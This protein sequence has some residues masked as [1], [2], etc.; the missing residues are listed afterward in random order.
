MKKN[1]FVI[2]VMCLVLTSCGKVTGN[3]GGRFPLPQTA[4]IFLI[5][6]Y[7]NYAW[8]YQ[9]DG[10]FVDTS[11]AVY[12]F[13]FGITTLNSTSDEQLFEKFDIIRDNTE[14]ITT[15]DSDTIIELYSL[16]SQIDP[17]SEFHSKK[18][19]VDAGS[20]TVSF[21]NPDTGRKTVCTEY[22]DDE[23]TRSDSFSQKFVKLYNIKKKLPYLNSQ[24]RLFTLRMT[25][26]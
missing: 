5:D 10:I 23:G 9:D 25:Y 2:S 8:G 18:V 12:A 1:L 16:G 17:E 22:G 20:H 19:A 24:R 4:E 21:C 11:G 13:D 15:I 7:V 6:R 26:T 3:D 14:P